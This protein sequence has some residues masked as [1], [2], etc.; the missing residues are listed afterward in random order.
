[1]ADCIAGYVYYTYSC[2]VWFWVTIGTTVFGTFVANCISLRWHIQ[3]VEEWD[4]WSTI[5]HMFQMSPLIRC[6][7]VITRGIILNKE[8]NEDNF[9]VSSE[10]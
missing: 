3:D 2:Y 6:Y 9:N 7:R 10:F 8:P 4:L 5:Y 1:M